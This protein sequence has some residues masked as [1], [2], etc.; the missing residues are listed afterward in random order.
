MK[1]IVLFFCLAAMI[2]G[3]RAATE[4]RN[5]TSTEGKTIRG[6]I[7]AYDART[8]TVTI[9]L[10]NKRISKA[11]ITVFSEDDQIY[12]RDWEIMKNF[13]AGS[14]FKVSAKR[15]RQDNESESSS[16]YNSKREVTDTYY[17]LILENRSASEMENIELEY[18]IYYEQEV[19]KA[20][21][22]SCDDGVYCGKTTTVSVASRA[23]TTIKT[24]AVSIYREELDADWYYGGSGADNVQNGKVHGIWI[25]VHL[26]L[27]S[28]FNETREFLFPDSISNSR[29][30]KS[31]SIR[32]G[33]N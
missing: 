1:R 15:K 11:P 33:M 3:V 16:D 25:R 5:F 7:R 8:Q 12:I 2:S 13:T 14:A 9:E 32:A 27:P 23:K 17:E 6:S 19:I 28:G 24:D 20:G 30:W 26:K 21:G 22:E 10:G 29:S 31:S 4:Y 18:C